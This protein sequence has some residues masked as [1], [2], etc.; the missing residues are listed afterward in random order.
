MAPVSQLFN[1]TN[2]FD[3]FVADNL[4]L[5]SAMPI[6]S[7][8]YSISTNPRIAYETADANLTMILL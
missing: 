5:L 6:T 7:I 1:T 4:N 3:R 8:N 2:V